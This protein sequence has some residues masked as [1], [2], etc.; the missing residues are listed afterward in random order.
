MPIGKI[1][2]PPHDPRRNLGM[3]PQELL[4]LIEDED[5][6]S[7][8]VGLVEPFAQSAVVGDLVEGSEIEVGWQADRVERISGRLEDAA[9]DK[10]LDRCV[11]PLA[12][13]AE[14]LPLDTCPFP[15]D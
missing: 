15:A 3:L 9:G 8:L 10:H 11:R 4:E 5:R 12:W 2:D 13:R 1:E 7:L 6:C 14:V